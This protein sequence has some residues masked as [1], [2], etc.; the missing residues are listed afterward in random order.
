MNIPFLEVNFAAVIVSTVLLM[1]AGFI[2]YSP[3]V[4][5]TKWMEL[6][7]IDPKKGKDE[8]GAAMAEG[9]VAALLASYFLALLLHVLQVSS[10]LEAV[11][12]SAL[13]W[14][15]FALPME[16]DEV[17]WERRPVGLCGINLSFALLRAVIIAVT[18]VA[19]PW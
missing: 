15:A 3:A 6:S 14:L 19:W 17:A 7:G 2:W 13:A 10:V 4:F 16:L 12:Y 18:L 9:I 5:G 1:I 11:G 8:M